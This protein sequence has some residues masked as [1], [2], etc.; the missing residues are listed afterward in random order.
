VLVAA[1]VFVGQF[2]LTF[3]Q[4]GY[5]NSIQNEQVMVNLE[6]RGWVM[7]IVLATVKLIDAVG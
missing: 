3:R 7:G 4:A 5:V 6:A 2:H 1:T